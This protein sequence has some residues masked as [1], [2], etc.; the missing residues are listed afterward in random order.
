[1]AVPCVILLIP[2]PTTHGPRLLNTVVLLR[3]GLEATTAF[4]LPQEA[5]HEKQSN[6]AFNRR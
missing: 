5:S 3:S 6:L 1:M 2:H 4:P